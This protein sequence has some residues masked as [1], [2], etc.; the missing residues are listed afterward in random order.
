MG[1][2]VSVRRREKMLRIRYEPEE[3]GRVGGGESVGS[4]RVEDV[5]YGSPRIAW[6]RQPVEIPQLVGES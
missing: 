6:L 4:D 2:V 1:V 5:H 3:S